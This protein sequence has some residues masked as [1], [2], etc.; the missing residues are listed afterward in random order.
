M[1]LITESV[2][3]DS[4]LSRGGGGGGGGSIRCADVVVVDLAIGV[5]DEVVD[6]G[7]VVGFELGVVETPLVEDVGVA[8]LGR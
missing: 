4:L 3:G 1:D 5:R 6:A 7:V 2:E 8:E